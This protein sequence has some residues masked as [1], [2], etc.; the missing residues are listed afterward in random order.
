[1]RSSTKTVVALNGFLGQ[2]SDWPRDLLPDGWTLRALA[3]DVALFDE[4]A[5]R[6]TASLTE[7]VVLLGY[8]LGGRLAMHALIQDPSKFLG[9][10]IVSANPGLTSESERAERRAADEKWAT[11]FESE[12]WD[13][14]M[15]D[16]N[17]QAVFRGPA[18]APERA[19]GDRARLANQMRTWSLGRQRDLRSELASLELPITFV[20]GEIDTK[21]TAIARELP[22]EHVVIENAG[23]R[24]PWDAPT[25]FRAQLAKFLSRW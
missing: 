7:P 10:M 22:F 5:S 8:S 9:A 20:T 24:V 15:R 21:F 14:L 6:F 1:M 13:Q 18:P 4:W 25:P 12:P 23:H 3:V 11:R 19:E 2:P 16:W 17:A